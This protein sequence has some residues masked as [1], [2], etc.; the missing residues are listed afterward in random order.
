MVVINLY[1]GPGSGKSTCAAYIFSKLKMAGY[2]V[3]L[4]TEFA[5]DVVWEG[6]RTALQN[7]PY[8]FGIQFYRISRLEGQVDIVVTD[9][10]L[11]NSVLYNEDK[12]LEKGMTE[13]ILSATSAYDNLNY[14]ITRTKPYRMSGRV[15]TENEANEVAERA[16]NMLLSHNIPY[17][18]FT[19]STEDYDEMYQDI[20][21]HL[22]SLKS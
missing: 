16:K 10:P 4:V 6:N 20:V 14:F 12:R 21:R 22:S 1:G 11:M 9:S 13:M 19:S 3:E 17:K 5:K 7:Q 15:Q 8:I 2:N 18:E